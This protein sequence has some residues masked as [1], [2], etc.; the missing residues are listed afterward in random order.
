M[1]EGHQAEV[2]RQFQLGIIRSEDYKSDKWGTDT[3]QETKDTPGASSSKDHVKINMI[4]I[5]MIKA[6]DDEDSEDF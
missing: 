2:E 3:T 6:R 4:R 1:T 5:K